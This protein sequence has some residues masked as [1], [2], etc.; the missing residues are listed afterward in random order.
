[1]SSALLLMLILQPSIDISSTEQHSAPPD[2]TMRAALTGPSPDRL[3]VAPI[4]GGQFFGGFV[5][6]FGYFACLHFS[7]S[8]SKVN[9]TVKRSIL[10]GPVG[11][12]LWVYS[13]DTGAPSPDYAS[14]PLC[15]VYLCGSIVRHP[16]DGARNIVTILLCNRFVGQRFTF[17]QCRPAALG[18]ATDRSTANG[19]GCSSEH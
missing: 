18:A 17:D 11:P 13:L 14:L 7:F 8:V 3:G 2:P 5:F 19:A 16:I 1:M 6:F 10:V 12:S 15:V 9:G 4:L